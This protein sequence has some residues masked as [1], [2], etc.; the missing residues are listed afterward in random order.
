M[1]HSVKS[2]PVTFRVYGH[3][4]EETFDLARDAIDRT[5][6]RIRP[7]QPGGTVTELRAAW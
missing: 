1:G 6:F 2:L 3:V 4:T 5:L 7:V